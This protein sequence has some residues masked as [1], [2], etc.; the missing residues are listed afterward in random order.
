MEEVIPCSPIAIHIVVVLDE[1][2]RFRAI[3]RCTVYSHVHVSGLETRQLR[4][5]R[6]LLQLSSTEIRLPPLSPTGR[7]SSIKT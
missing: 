2:F 4:P 6:I 1:S 5:R 7:I 3:H